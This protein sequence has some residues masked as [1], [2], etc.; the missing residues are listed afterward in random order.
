MVTALEAMADAIMHYEGWTPGSTSN[1][2]RNP[3]N[4]RESPLKI[5]ENAGGFCV[6]RD[7][8][9]G[10]HALLHDLE[11][12]ASGQNRHGIGPKSTLLQLFE[13]Y[14][15]SGDGNVP[16]KYAE[17]VATWVAHALHRSVTVNTTLENLLSITD[18]DIPVVCPDV[19]T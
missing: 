15:P 1:R 14:A 19:V 3:G 10:Y 8:P 17:F 7:L 11:C 6:F 16:F 2:N 5:G 9:T 12:K 18:P 4:L 13:V